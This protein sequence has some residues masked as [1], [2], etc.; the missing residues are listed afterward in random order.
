MKREIIKQGSRPL[1]YS[2]VLLPAL[3]IGCSSTATEETVPAVTEQVT[4]SVDEV[5]EAQIRN[6]TVRI[7]LPD[8]TENRWYMDSVYLEEQ[9]QNAGFDA[10]VYDG[11]NDNAKQTADIS[12][13][14]YE[15]TDLLIV[16]PVDRRGIT[17]F[18][19]D[20][21]EKGIPIILYD[22]PASDM[23]WVSYYVGFSEEDV[24]RYLE[25][26]VRLNEEAEEETEAAGTENEAQ[27]EEA[28]EEETDEG[29]ETDLLLRGESADEAVLKEIAD[30]EIEAAVYRD[31]T[32]EAVVALDLGIN[33]LY[34]EYADESLIPASEWGFPCR[35]DA[36]AP[37]RIPPA[38]FL[39]P[40]LI[41]RENMTEKLVI[42]GYYT[43]G[44]DGY[45]HLSEH[46]G[47][48]Q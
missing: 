42:P 22:R 8:C 3:L 45:L 17:A 34:G 5:P 4:E 46:S 30:G 32:G 1:R 12:G 13:I 21:G 25:E 41:T 14:D 9:F 11:E 28:Q 36:G 23:S 16:V 40:V 43:E 29:I 10:V 37:G 33:L 19:T 35:Y 47:G 6:G 31:V 7:F 15:E 27:E 24:Q 20:P 26:A 18:L 48:G 44:T 38:F 39:E 2:W